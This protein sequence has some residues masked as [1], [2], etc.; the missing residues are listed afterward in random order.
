MAR[1]S[2]AMAGAP[3]GIPGEL[4]A[5]KPILLK[6]APDLTDGQLDD[7]LGIVSATGIAGIIAT[8]TT[9][10]RKPLITDS[11]EVAALGNGGLSGAPVRQ[12][13]TEVIRYLYENS[14]KTLDIIGVGGIDSAASAREKMDAGAKLVQVYSGMVYA[15]PGLV[16]DIKK[17][18][19]KL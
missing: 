2:V 19:I 11:E 1:P 14:G 18:F 4:W 13:S 16:R 9:I 5:E 3:L 10:A 12:R 17:A 8:N 6:I 7:I 15:G